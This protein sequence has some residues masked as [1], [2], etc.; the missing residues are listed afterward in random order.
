MT[1][2][3]KQ[4]IQD[5]RCAYE[6]QRFDTVKQINSI[7]CSK[8]LDLTKICVSLQAFTSNCSNSLQGVLSVSEG[9]FTEKRQG[10]QDSEESLR[11]GE[12]I[13]DGLR[14]R[15]Q[16]ELNGYLAPPG[17][18][19]QVRNHPSIRAYFHLHSLTPPQ[20]LSGVQPLRSSSSGMPAYSCA[21]TTEL[22]GGG[23]A[24][25]SYDD[26]RHALPDDGVYKQV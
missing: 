15:L 18:P 9:S 8:K 17:S 23:T 11:L 1:A 7:D 22:L 3:H 13:Y 12:R 19:L 10:V 24:S 20:A 21:L 25:A 5:A 2:E 26:M 4:R 16:S 6:L 14:R